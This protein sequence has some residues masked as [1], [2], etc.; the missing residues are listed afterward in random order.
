MLCLGVASVPGLQHG[1]EEGPAVRVFV[2]MRK[3]F[4]IFY[5]IVSISVRMKTRRCLRFRVSTSIVAVWLPYGHIATG[6]YI[7]L[8]R[9]SLLSSSESGYRDKFTD[10]SLM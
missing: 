3:I 2:R 4:Q 6:Q 7:G 5:R 8:L 9:S 1:K 10:N